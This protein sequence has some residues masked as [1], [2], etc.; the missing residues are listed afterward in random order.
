MSQI[1]AKL[2]HLAQKL[3]PNEPEPLADFAGGCGLI[4]GVEVDAGDTVVEEVGA[5]LG[6]VVEANLADGFGGAVGALESFEEF[7]GEAATAGEFGHAFHRAE[8]GDGHDAGDD[9]GADSCQ[10][11]AVAEVV[12]IVIIEEKLGADIVGTGLHLGFEVVHFEQ[13]VGGGWVAFGKSRNADAKSSLVRVAGEF[14]DKSNQVCRL[15]KCI[16]RVVVVGLVA[17]WVPA[18]GED[19]AYSSGGVAFKNRGDF[20][21]RVADT[22]EVRNRIERRGGFEPQHEFVG[23]F[24]S[25]AARS[26]GD[27]DKVGLDFFEIP[28]R[29]VE[30]I[31]RLGRLWREKLEGDGRLAGLEDVVD[32]HVYAFDCF[33]TT[34][35]KR[36]WEFMFLALCVLCG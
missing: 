10:R 29:S 23:E 27:A 12:E 36:N 24:A 6:G 19:V 28:N 17:G 1:G 31:L 4:E 35:R 8:A 25:G 2:C 20:G 21:L 22:S 32:V 13:A 3:F 26:V 11:A 30:L 16:A 7:R 9:G 34:E 15:G 5:L 18:E 14:F 33:L